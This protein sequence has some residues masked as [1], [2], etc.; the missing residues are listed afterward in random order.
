MD[1][2]ESLSWEWVLQGVRGK[3]TLVRRRK[4]N[5]GGGEEWRTF[6]RGRGSRKGGVSS[7]PRPPWRED[8]E[9]EDVVRPTVRGPVRGPGKRGR[10]GKGGKKD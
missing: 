5:Q 1:E 6:Q 8:R 3:R 2:T 4:F 10:G 9:G 7:A